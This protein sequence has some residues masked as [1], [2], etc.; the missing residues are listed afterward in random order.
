MQRIKLIESKEIK[1]MAKYLT[2]QG[3]AITFFGKAWSGCVNNW[4]Y[5][6]TI[7]EIEELIEKFSL[8]SNISIHENLDP[9]S[10]KERGFIDNRTGEGI[11]GIIK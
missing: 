10:G 7:L 5:F 3:I 1:E 9:K 8:D 6:D 4:I 11:M 2:K